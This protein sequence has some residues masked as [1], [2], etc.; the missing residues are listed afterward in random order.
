MGE[1][2]GIG[3]CC[4]M[5][6]IHAGN[7]QKENGHG[8]ILMPCCRIWLSALRKKT[9]NIRMKYLVQVLFL[10]VF[11]IY[12]NNIRGDVVAQFMVPFQNCWQNQGKLQKKC[13]DN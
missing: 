13:Q 10:Y 8:L 1:T 3:S 11:H 4:G 12:V 7:A 5:L 9:E 6:H 2:T